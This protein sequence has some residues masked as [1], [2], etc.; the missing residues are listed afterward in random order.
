MV[1]QKCIFIVCFWLN[2][3]ESIFPKHSQP[4]HLN[5]LWLLYSL[6]HEST[7]YSLTLIIHSSKGL[8]IPTST[9]VIALLRNMLNQHFQI[10]NYIYNPFYPL[11]PIWIKN[12]D[13]NHTIQSFNNVRLQGLL[14]PFQHYPFIHSC[15]V[16]HSIHTIVV[17]CWKFSFFNVDI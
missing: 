3:S 2:F 12:H 16:F 15:V 1:L 11:A 9:W 10:F 14:C 13:W 17:E 5:L 7:A 6:V 4:S 8:F